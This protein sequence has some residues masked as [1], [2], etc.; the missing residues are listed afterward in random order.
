MSRYRVLIKDLNDPVLLAQV[1]I[2]NQEHK[3]NFNTS[4]YLSFILN[5]W[6][7]NNVTEITVKRR[8]SKVA[9]PTDISGLTN[10]DY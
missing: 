2:Y 1:K 6:F 3:T 4:E 9:S 7:E 5:K 10:Y 8:P